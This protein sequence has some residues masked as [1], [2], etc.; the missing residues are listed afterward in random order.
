[1]L[2]KTTSLDNIQT[3]LFEEIDDNLLKELNLER[4]NYEDIKN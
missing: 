2:Y 4:L 3:R 1:M